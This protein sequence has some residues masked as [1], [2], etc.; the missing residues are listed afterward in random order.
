[1]HSFQKVD[2]LTRACTFVYLKV[3]INLQRWL[4]DAITN[5]SQQLLHSFGIQEFLF[6][7]YQLSI[8]ICDCVEE[9]IGHLISIIKII[10]RGA[11]GCIREIHY[12]YHIPSFI[13]LL[14]I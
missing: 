13:N 8:V 4:G 9:L 7:F 1:M 11:T 12:Y 10:Q 2:A 14:S 5:L 6:T 3:V